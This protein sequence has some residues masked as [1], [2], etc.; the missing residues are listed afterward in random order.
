MYSKEYKRQVLVAA[1]TYTGGD[2]D[3]YCTGVNDQV[4][5]DAALEFA[6][7]VEF[8]EGVFY[9]NAI[10]RSSNRTIRGRG[11][12]IFTGTIGASGSVLSLIENVKISDI[13]SCT[14]LYFYYVGDFIA[15]S[16]Y[17]TYVYAHQVSQGK[18]IYCTAQ[19]NTNGLWDRNG[20]YCDAAE[21]VKLISCVSKDQLGCGYI[22]FGNNLQS[23][24]CYGINNGIGMTV[25]GDE[26]LVGNA[27][28]INNQQKVTSRTLAGGTL[29]GGIYVTGDRN[30]ISNCFCKNNGNLIDRSTCE[31]SSTSPMIF[32]E[33]T[34]TASNCTWG[35]TATSP[36]ESNGQYRFS[37]T[38]AAGTKAYLHLVDNVGTGDLHGLIPG[39]QYEWNGW[40]KCYSSASGGYQGFRFYQATTG[41]GATSATVVTAATA[42][43][44]W[45]AVT[46]TIYA[47]ATTAYLGLWASSSLGSTTYFDV[48][49]VRLYP[50]GIVNPHNQNFYDGGA[51][52]S[53]V[54]SWI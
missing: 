9:G 20:F 28:L 31:S 49:N 50:P 32:G 39:T 11:N 8:T 3:Y 27:V 44:Q 52:T 51:D 14:R 43:W 37:K 30:Q 25:A 12:T 19:S 40:L 23:Y 48:D 36:Y 18:L 54:N 21:D 7:Y 10:I 6:P 1:S 38:V 41:G 42:S 24:Q 33:S 17:T 53:S 47:N 29:C 16:I 2:A 5:I 26:C 15:E 22:L 35:F 4:L 45:I 34:P 46:A 13:A